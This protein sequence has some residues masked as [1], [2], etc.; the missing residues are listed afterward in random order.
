LLKRVDD[1]WIDPLE[2]RPDS[3]LGVP[4]LLQAVRSGNVL[5][6]NTPGSGFLESNAL[7][8]FMPGLA[9]E[10]LGQELQLPAIPS[11][12][13]GEAAARASAEQHFS[14]SILKPSYP[15]AD[16]RE[17]FETVLLPMLSPSEQD[18]WRRRIDD[19]PEAYT[20]QSQLAL[21]EMPVWRDALSQQPYLL[22][23]FALRTGPAPDDWQMMPGAMARVVGQ[24]QIASMQRG[25]SSADVWLVHD[26]VNPLGPVLPSRPGQSTEEAL[27]SRPPPVAPPI[28]HRGVTSR[29]AENLFWMGRYAERS[30]NSLRLA[31]VRL[32]TLL[33]ESQS[34][35]AM[36][37]CGSAGLRTSTST[38]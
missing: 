18:Q 1:D 5:V 16:G 38:Q 21:G 17:S 32:D 36:T 11:W 12:W 34:P 7:L 6:A 19:D 28:V 2:L 33:A 22:R 25:G 26:P 30:E 23:V 14:R 20:V 4:G 27:G 8:G 37:G 35:S 13:C 9:R 31:Q 15:Q 3:T 29:A 10:L 24:Q